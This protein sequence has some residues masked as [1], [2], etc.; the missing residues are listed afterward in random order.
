MKYPK[1]EDLNSSNCTERSIEIH[2][3]EFWEYITKNYKCEK[4]TERL[5]WF[6]HN[7]ND[8]PKCPVCGNVPKFINLKLGYR[9]FCGYKCMNSYNDIQE[10]KKETSRKNWGVDN[11]MQSKKVQDKLR[12]SI[13]EKY[14]VNNAFQ[15]SDFKE[16]RIRTNL[17]K[18]G[19]EH[20]LQN[21]VIKQKL[22]KTQRL[23]NIFIDSNLIGYTNDG[24]QI[25]KCTKKDCNKCK[26]KYY[27]TPT[28]I[29]FDRNRLGY[30]TCTNLVPIGNSNKSSLEYKVKEL[31]DRYNIQYISNNRKLMHDKK[32]LD[33]F[34][35]KFNLAIECNGIWSHSVMNNPSPK[36]RN[37]HINKTK[38]CRKYNIEVIHLWEDWIMGKWDIVESMLLNKLGI[39]DKIYARNTEIR[40]I[41]V[42]D[43][44][45]FIERNH[46]QGAP[47][48]TH[49]RLGLYYKNEL[50]SVM[51]F[52]IQNNEWHLDRFCSKLNTR[53]VGGASKLLNY[54]IKHYDPDT[55][56]SF[57]SNDISNGNLY[58]QLGFKS[59]YKYQQSYWYF[60]P[61]TLKRDH[62]SSWSKSEIVR[63]GIKEK[64]DDTW[65]EFEVMEELGFFCIYDSGQFKWILKLKK[66]SL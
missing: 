15:A 9:E 1:L 6:Y 53:V 29:Y 62:R 12:E 30:E 56:I 32:E 5:Y 52:T 38:Q 41:S 18:Y 65:T 59:D 4:W 46:I 37:Y 13:Q 16:K 49:V 35:P 54:F 48:M 51:T 40:E 60:R 36:P 11:P 2:Y 26:K 10:R 55:I 7:L 28:N 57:S 23:K 17:K 42:K 20:H 19:V 47:V 66:T 64:I 43:S 27:I 58:K 63:K 33:I 50:V 45:E 14:G 44:K 39:T 8:Y 24:Q 3:P 31:L 34:I 61:G 22:I 25:R 21:E